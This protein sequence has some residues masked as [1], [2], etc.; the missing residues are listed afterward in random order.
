MRTLAFLATPALLLTLAWSPPLWGQV[1]DAERAAARELFKEGDDL[2]RAGKMAEALDK[3][4]R[5]QKVYSAPTNELRIAQCQAALGRLAE[6]AESYRTVLRM[7]L[8]AGS[9]PAFQAAVDQAKTELA[10]VEPRVPKLVVQVAP[11]NANPQL[12]IDGQSV[13]AA[14][15]GEPLPLDPGTHRVRVVAQGFSS[16]DQDAVL[17]EHETTTVVATL[18]PLAPLAPSSSATLPP[19]PSPVAAPPQ[20]TGPTPEPGAP[21]PYIPPPPP[22]IAEREVTPSQSASRLGI[23]AGAHIG[24]AIGTGGFPVGVTR[25][26]AST[27]AGGGPA[28]GLEGGLRFARHWY[29]GLIFEH[30]ELTHGDLSATLPKVTDASSSTNVLAAMIAFIVNPDRTSFYGE[31]G[32]GTRWFDFTEKF[33]NGRDQT[34]SYNGAELDLGIGLW[35]PLGSSIRLLPKMTLGIGGFDTPSPLAGVSANSQGHTFFLIGVTGLF[36]LDF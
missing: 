7:P 17:R 33:Q 2:Q 1:T 11:T 24:W 30:A 26:E 32:V 4:Q 16:S 19:P 3:F 6:S 15:V 18:K 27:V 29:V 22:R 10:Q 31:I 20:A 8:P 21:P 23:L 13:S 35:L 5:A 9:P 14:L 12:L 34:G 28:Y 25:V 36:N